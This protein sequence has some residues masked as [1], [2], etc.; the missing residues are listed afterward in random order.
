MTTD[1][2]GCECS[3]LFL[4]HGMVLFS[5]AGKIYLTQLSHCHIQALSGEICITQMAWNS[6][7][8]WISSPVVDDHKEYSFLKGSYQL[9]SA[10]SLTDVIN[11]KL[12]HSF[13]EITG[14]QNTIGGGVGGFVFQASGGPVMIGEENTSAQQSHGCLVAH[15]FWA[16]LC[17]VIGWCLKPEIMPWSGRE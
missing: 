7:A 15:I 17:V 12:R 9:Y 4:A 13:S 2:R 3:S 16:C 1:L 11:S 6:C 5:F 10:A 14:F 8:F